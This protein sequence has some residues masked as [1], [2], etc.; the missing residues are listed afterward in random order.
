MKFVA[1]AT[2]VA[3]VSAANPGRDRKTGETCVKGE[4]RCCL[5]TKDKDGKDT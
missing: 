5:P 2:L 3:A 1:L 4:D